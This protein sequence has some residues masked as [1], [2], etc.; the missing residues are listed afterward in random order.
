MKEDINTYL[1]RWYQRYLDR[2]EGECML[3][4]KHRSGRPSLV[5]PEDVDTAV[6]QFT[7]GYYSHG[8]WRP[9]NSVEEVGTQH[10]GG[11]RHPSTNQPS[12]GALHLLPSPSLPACPTL[13]AGM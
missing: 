8:R 9:Y 7:H 1:R 3:E 5:T 10:V 13:H 12:T 4:E 11:G 6:Q 2:E